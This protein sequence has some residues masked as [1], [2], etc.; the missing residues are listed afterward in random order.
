[1]VKWHETL[2]AQFA[3]RLAGA[4]VLS[5]AWWAGS[6]LYTRVHAHAPAPASLAE[7]AI[8][9]VFVLLLI[10]GNALLFVGP[11]LWK[12]IEIPGR[13]S[14]VLIEPRQF[15]VLLNE[16]ASTE[17]KFERVTTKAA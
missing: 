11:G 7:L 6:S 8:C 15:D 10:I 16:Q 17:T 2:A 14:A 12:Q 5:G 13:W 1:M 3:L 4:V 9:A